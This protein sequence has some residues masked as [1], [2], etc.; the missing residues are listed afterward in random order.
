M[1]SL[2]HQFQRARLVWHLRQ[3]AILANYIVE[4]SILTIILFSV[5][6]KDVGNVYKWLTFRPKGLHQSQIL[7]ADI[8]DL[9][10]RSYLYSNCK[11][12][13]FLCQKDLCQDISFTSMKELI[14][15]VLENTFI[16]MIQYAAQN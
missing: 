10:G 13:S 4:A 11:L 6:C 9:L 5:F 2:Q 3:L 1:D 12:K 8:S 16:C 7:H 14:V 15:K